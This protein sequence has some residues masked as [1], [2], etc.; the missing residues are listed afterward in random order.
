[1]PK[2]ASKPMPAET[3][4]II[5]RPQSAPGMLETVDTAQGI[6]EATQYC[7]E[8]NIADWAAYYFPSYLSADEIIAHRHS[9]YLEI[10]KRLLGRV[11]D[12]EMVL[13]QLITVFGM[14]NDEARRTI[15]RAHA[16][17]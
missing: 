13:Q 6:I 12:V 8:Y 7:E 5:R 16:H 3:M 1:M 15:E 11:G 10:T 4:Y 2:K 14:P 9:T 17:A